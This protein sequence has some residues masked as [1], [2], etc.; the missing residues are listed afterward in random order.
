[1]TQIQKTILNGEIT[2]LMETIREQF[3][4]L[5]SFEG[6]IPILEF[7]IIKD[8]V[9]K[10]YEKLY[11]LQ[12][13][14]DPYD[15][16]KQKEQ[17]IIEDV[18]EP[19]EAE[20]KS[21]KIDFPASETPVQIIE[22]A[23]EPLETEAGSL[24]IDI[25]SSVT[26]EQTFTEKDEPSETKRDPEKID[27]FTSETTAFNDKL[28]EAREQTLGPRFRQST[29]GD[30]KSIININDKFL[31]I[32][33]LFDGDYKEYTH[34]IEIFNNFDDKS[35]AFEFLDSLLKNNLWNSTSSAFL[36]LKEIVEKKFI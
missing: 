9:R 6:K 11:L 31:F 22:E 24:K 20:V 23:Y 27:L 4:T 32:N 1:M 14:N 30:I 19:S 2:T 5:N 12:R 3:E 35:E 10:L 26:S 17:E 8:N 21:V 13:M 34:T 29:P 25:S 33:E 36:K 28:K 16:I 7:E 15:S 18:N